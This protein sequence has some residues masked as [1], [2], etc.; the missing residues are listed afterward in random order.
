M[1]AA[2]E[3]QS[4]SG[5]AHLKARDV[6][7]VMASFWRLGHQP[8]AP[9]L[10]E[11]SQVV[12]DELPSMSAASAARVLQLFAAFSWDGVGDGR[13]AGER[14]VFGG[15]GGR[16]LA[17]MVESRLQREMAEL[18]P[19]SLSTSLLGFVR[20]RH[21]PA[22]AFLE[23]ANARAQDCLEAF[24]PSDFAMFMWGSCR[25]GGLQ[26]AGA[27]LPGA[28]AAYDRFAQNEGADVR[29]LA[30]VAQL[31]HRGHK[32]SGSALGHLGEEMVRTGNLAAGWWQEIE[33]SWGDE[34]ERRWESFPWPTM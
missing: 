16:A 2:L 24:S 4:M 28:L 22:G 1:L 11:A 10:E 5:P 20:T 21:R 18:S 29:L 17:H 30:E 12:Q 6:V 23:A 26:A 27:D 34:D 15:P 32:V 7:E 9:W 3:A 14:G 8:G 31:L 19:Y 13:W 25:L 33:S